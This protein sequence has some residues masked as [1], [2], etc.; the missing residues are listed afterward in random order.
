M[1]I[2]KQHIVLSGWKLVNKGSL[3]QYTENTAPL[4]LQ[5]ISTSWNN[6]PQLT[7]K[8]YYD[9]VGNMTKDGEGNDIVYN[10]YNQ[11][12]KVTQFDGQQISYTYDGLGRESMEK[13]TQGINYLIYRGNHL[14]NEKISNPG[15]TEHITGYQEIAKTIDGA[16]YQYNE[17]NYKVDVVNI[18]IKSEQKSNIYKLQKTNIYSPYGMVWHQKTQDVS[19]YQRSLLGFD[20]E[21]TDPATGWQFLG[22]GHKTYNPKQRCFVNEDPAGGGYA[23]GSNNPVMNS[24][25]TGDIPQW[26][27]TAFKWA[28]YISSFGLSALHARWTNIVG[29]VIN[30]GLTIATL[31]ASACSYGALSGLVVTAGAALAGSMPVAAAA[32]TTNKGLKIAGAA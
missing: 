24:D 28:G 8:L 9:I 21:R 18:L 12:I 30:T 5:K 22:G 2:A 13:S 27:S 23:F 10:A 25:P 14:A 1:A 20:G 17:S 4:R 31:G 6:R 15:Q 26:V 29:E 19:L 32:I 3:Y 7:Q 16:L 11:I